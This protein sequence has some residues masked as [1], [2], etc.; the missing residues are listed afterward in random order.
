MASYPAVIEL[1]VD[2]ITQVTRVLDT[3]GK[4]DN[5][6]VSIKKTPLAIDSKNATD[7]IRVLKKEVDEFIF[8]LGRGN[9]QLAST[10]AGINAQAA[11]FR[12]L[13]ANAKIGGTAFNLY[14]QAAEQA[15]QKSSLKGGLADI[16]AVSNLYKV[17]KTAPTQSFKGIDELIKFGTTVPKNTASLEL[18]RA[19]L[20]RVLDVVEYGTTDYRNLERAIAGVNK[21]LQIGQGLGGKQGPAAPAARGLGRLGTLGKRLPGAISGGVIGGV[22]PLLF[23]QGGGAATGGAIGG[24]AGGLLGPGGSFAGSLLGTLLGDIAS[25]GQKIKQ[26]GTDIGFSAQQ[27]NVLAEGFK[28]A[29]TDIEKFTAVVQNIRGLGLELKDQAALIQV[30]TNLTDKYGGSFDKVGNAITSALESGR[31]SQATLNQLTSQGINIQDALATKLGV[32]RDAL[33]EMAK[34]GKISLQTLVDTLVEVGNAGA[35]AAAKPKTGFDKLSQSAKNLG[36]AFSDLGGAIVKNLTPALNWLAERLAGLVSLAAQVIQ[37]IAKALSGG[38]A[39]DVKAS[40]LAGKAT[41]EKFPELKQRLSGSKSPLISGG[42]LTAGGIAALNPA[43]RKFFEAQVTKATTG[44]QT[45]QTKVTGV[46]V[47]ALGQAPP[48]PEPKG[49]KGKSGES[50]AKRLRN[51]VLNQ[52]AITAELKNQYA[53]S[54]KIFAAEMAKDP[55]LARRLEGEQQLKDWGIETVKLL[56]KEKT[57][58]GQLAIAKAQQAKQ[59]VIRQKIEQDLARLEKQRLETVRNTIGGLQNELNIKNATTQAERDRL[60]IAYE[61]QQLKEGGGYTDQELARIQQLKAELATPVLGADLIKQQIGGLS[62]EMVKLVDVGYQVTQA[63]ESIGSAFGN[64]FKGVI[65]GAMTAQE[66]LASFFQSVADRFLDMAAQIIAKWIEMTILNSVLNLFPGGN[67]L[68]AVAAGGGGGGAVN[69]MN[70][71]TA[72]G[73]GFAA[74]GGPVTGGSPYVVG[75]RGP[76]L[77]VP[78]RS[79]TIIPNNQLGVSGATNVVVNVDASGSNVQ[80]NGQEANQLGKAIGIAVQQELIKQKRPGGLLA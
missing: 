39:L 59:A 75:E 35:T 4:L 15:R 36:T 42:T 65:T 76:E 66:A 38:S 57:E 24:L 13:A 52:Q 64:S 55:Q 62:D 69:F 10:T 79:G 8:K 80:G 5:A 73:L 60:R 2:G 34:K 25:Q 50:E 11:A 30:V 51:L 21:Q 1:R 45:Q 61:M 78:G 37:G 49:P 29:N 71:A 33:L 44:L 68:G 26:L 67:M 20:T 54:E 3:I 7:G 46:N 70:N 63:A 6:L 77:F 27:A 72:Q 16:A 53:Y 43:E 47:S 12:N 9:A 56:Q 41:L 48:S 32:S 19:E 58:T 23:G 18:Y 17:G 14:T 28:K 74:N 31:V 22:F 40:A